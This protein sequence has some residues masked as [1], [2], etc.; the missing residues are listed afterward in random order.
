M[1]LCFIS[2]T[3]ES[4][5]LQWSLPKAAQ[6]VW[7]FYVFLS[8]LL[9]NRHIS[10][11]ICIPKRSK[12]WSPAPACTHS[13]RICFTP[14]S[15]AEGG[16]ERSSTVVF[17]LSS[18]CLVWQGE[19]TSLCSSIFQSASLYTGVTTNVLKGNQ[20]AGSP[21]GACQSWSQTG[22]WRKVSTPFLSLLVVRR[23]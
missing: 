2:K 8:H 15:L 12:L 19:T 4:N 10:H 20:V 22:T 23:C 16:V 11:S 17:P 1:I 18:K 3:Q 6:Y 9:W 13:V 14:Q 21:F 7:F 5:S